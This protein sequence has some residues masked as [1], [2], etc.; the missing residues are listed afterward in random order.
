MKIYLAAD[1]A[2]FELKEKLVPYLRDELGHDVE[3]CGAFELDMKDDYPPIIARAARKLSSDAAAGIESRAIFVGASGQGE[4]MVANRFPRVRCALY[5]GAS[6]EMQRDASGLEY[7][8]LASTRMHNNDNALSL[9]GR[10]MDE[11]EAKSAIKRWLETPF[12]GEVR[13][14]RRIG[15]IE[16]VRDEA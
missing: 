10:F 12:S 16:S 14:M 6:K 15:Q 1:H 7:D 3:D 11:G 4:A 2:G 5:Y 9:A 8:M 13:H